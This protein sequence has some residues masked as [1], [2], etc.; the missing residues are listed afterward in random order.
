MIDVNRLQS[1]QDELV[2]TLCLLE[3]YFLP[4]FFDV[5][6]HLIGHRVREVKL[7]GHVWFRWMY[8]FEHFMKVL[9]GYLR[10]GN[11]VEGCMAECYIAEEVLEYCVEYIKDVQAVGVLINQNLK[12]N[13]DHGIR[14]AVV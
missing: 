3:M 10:K 5:M 1:I 12:K 9:K 13:E 14:A 7:C 11:N 2:T 6:V 8:P 4:A